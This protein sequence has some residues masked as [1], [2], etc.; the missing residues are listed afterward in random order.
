MTNIR[1]AWKEL[2]CLM[3]MVILRHDEKSKQLLTGLSNSK[4]AELQ[5]SK[6]TELWLLLLMV[7]QIVEG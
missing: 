7:D 3:L 6:A 2:L 1:R 5:L 4:A